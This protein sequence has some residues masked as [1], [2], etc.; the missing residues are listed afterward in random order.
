MRE[1]QALG[2][3]GAI[4]IGINEILKV[5]ERDAHLLQRPQHRQQQLKCLKD[6][7]VL[8]KAKETTEV[9]GT[10]IALPIT[11]KPMGRG[12]R[13]MVLV[14]MVLEAGVPQKVRDVTEGEKKPGLES[15]SW[16]RHWERGNLGR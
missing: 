1:L 13:V 9:G 16:D 5:D 8:A 3:E 2:N 14:P 11:L 10:Q 15:I 4:G 6:G 12:P 7:T